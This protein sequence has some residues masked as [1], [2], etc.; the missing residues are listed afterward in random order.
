MKNLLV[1]LLTLLFLGSCQ[2]QKPLPD[3]PQGVLVGVRVQPDPEQVIT[4]SAVDED[5]IGDVNI[6]LCGKA[7]ETVYHTYSKS[8]SVQLNA[9]PDNY[10]IYV[11]ANL[12]RDL[13]VMSEVQLADFNFSADDNNTFQTDLPMSYRGQV[14]VQPSNGSSSVTLAPIVVRRNAARINYRIATKVPGLTLKSLQFV[15][16]PHRI[17]PFAE[18]ALSSTHKADY[19]AGPVI[20]LTDHGNCEG[21]L[22]MAPNRQGENNKIRHQRDKSRANAPACATYM[23]IRAMSGTSV[24][25]YD[26]FLG[27]NNTTDFNVSA[28]SVHNMSVTILGTD[29]VDTRMTSYSVNIVEVPESIFSDKGL[30]AGDLIQGAVNITGDLNAEGFRVCFKLLSEGLKLNRNGTSEQY[31]DLP[32]SG[33]LDYEL[34]YVPGVV[35]AEN[36]VAR[37][38]IEIT[39]VDGYTMVFQRAQ[40]W[41]NTLTVFTRNK[42]I[43]DAHGTVTVANDYF[44]ESMSGAAWEYVQARCLKEGCILTAVPNPGCAFLGWYEDADES[45]LLSAESTYRYVPEDMD[46][47]VYARFSEPRSVRLSTDIYNVLFECSEKYTVD[48]DADCFVVPYGSIC[49]ITPVDYYKGFQYFGWFDSEKGGKQLAAT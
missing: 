18:D 14:T 34:G 38:N 40:S 26:V 44:H 28:N 5:K 36:H 48:Q 49:K 9:I 32:T 47:I 33:V 35:S 7:T 8:A 6:Y 41:Y 21:V 13:G 45:Y 23:R 20:D 12:H 22:Y 3:H 39:D 1:S 24:Y 4:R 29:E 2:Q 37:Y 25:T 16:L 11:I 17:Y 46:G 30:G 15:N 19:A 27:E 43:E 31:F 42:M 10:T